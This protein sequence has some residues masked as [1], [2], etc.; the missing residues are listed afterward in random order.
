[1]HSAAVTESL[2]HAK[3]LRGENMHPE[4]VKKHLP[5]S[6]AS[7]YHQQRDESEQ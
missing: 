4:R 3:N 7:F 5:P 6:D 1:M 2:I